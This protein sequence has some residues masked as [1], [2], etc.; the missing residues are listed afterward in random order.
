[1]ITIKG[2]S[3]IYEG[4]SIDDMY[5]TGIDVNTLFHELSTNKWYYFTT[6]STWVEVPNTGGGGSGF[7][8]TQAQLD[9]MNSGIDSTKVQQISTNETNISLIDHASG[10]KL[11][12]TETE[13]TGSI[14]SGSYWISTGGTQ[15]YR[16]CNQI[17]DKTTAMVE[18]RFIRVAAP[19]AESPLGSEVS[20]ASYNCSDYINVLPNTTYTITYP[21]T[22]AAYSAGLAEFTSDE[23]Y[24]SGVSVAEQGQTYTFTTSPTTSKIRF[25]WANSSGNNVMLNEGN[26][27]MPYEDYFISGWQSNG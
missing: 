12:F 23:T 6:S 8:P 1:M 19:T 16:K 9:A 21:T 15:I 22:A 5:T 4:P 18:G 14:I 25:S 11:Y 7:T 20:N 2:S 13:P 26:I 3:A 10:T 27:A 24:I 17:F